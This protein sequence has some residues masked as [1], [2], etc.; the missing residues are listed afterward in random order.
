MM[1]KEDDKE[2]RDNR[3]RWR[4]QRKILRYSMKQAST[5]RNRLSTLSIAAEDQ[6]SLSLVTK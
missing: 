5:N 3:P 2:V 6:A 1:E 4:K